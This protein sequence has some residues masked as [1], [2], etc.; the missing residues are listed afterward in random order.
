MDLP[1]VVADLRRLL[2]ELKAADAAFLEIPG[3]LG[4]LL[5]ACVRESNGS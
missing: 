4:A 5:K 2:A 1:A 3:S